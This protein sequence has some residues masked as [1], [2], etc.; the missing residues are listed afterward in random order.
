MLQRRDRVHA[1]HSLLSDGTSAG[2]PV[3]PLRPRSRLRAGGHAAQA[4]LMHP[5][6]NWGWRTSCRVVCVRAQCFTGATEFTQITHF[7]PTVRPRVHLL[8]RYARAL[9]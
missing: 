8:S 7:Y 9:V 2:A 4:A 1:D 6:P 5:Q 3:I